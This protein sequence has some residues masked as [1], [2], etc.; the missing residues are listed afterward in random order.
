MLTFYSFCICDSDDNKDVVFDVDLL[1]LLLALSR[2]RESYGSGDSGTGG[3]NIPDL[4]ND[5]C[6]SDGDDSDDRVPFLG[7]DDKERLPLEEE[8]NA[9][10][11]IG[12]NDS[13]PAPSCCCCEILDC[14]SFHL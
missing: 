14:S 9:T 5:F 6:R 2:C 13:P 12:N 11:A 1:L 3:R 4:Q 7:D 8:E 10:E